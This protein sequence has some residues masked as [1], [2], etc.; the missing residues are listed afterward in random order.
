[1][2]GKG[3]DDHGEA[4]IGLG[5]MEYCQPTSPKTL[6]SSLIWKRRSVTLPVNQ[7][8]TRCWAISFK[9]L[10]ILDSQHWHQQE[11]V[12]NVFLLDKSIKKYCTFQN[13]RI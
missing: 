4:T 12:L 10:N 6:V 5:A 11:N 3:K 13:I 8:G 9:R 2:I 1:M 7:Y